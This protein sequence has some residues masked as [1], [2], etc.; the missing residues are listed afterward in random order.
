MTVAGRSLD[1]TIHR[2]LAR[3][4]ATIGID[5]RYDGLV[6]RVERLA[7]IGRRLDIW[8][9]AL[10]AAPD[11]PVCRHRLAAALRASGAYDRAF[12]VIEEAGRLFPQ[13]L[14]TMVE[15]ARVAEARSEHAGASE[16]WTRAIAAA[17]TP[18]PRWLSRAA[19]ALVVLGRFDEAEAMLRKAR[20]DHPRRADLLATACVLATSR[21]DWTQAVR[22]STEFQR[23]FP[24][25][26]DAWLL[27][28]AARE[29]AQLSEAVHRGK[30]P[31]AVEA[32]ADVGRVE[33][34]EARRLLLGFAGLGENCEFGLVQR[35]FGA[36]PVDLLRWNIVWPESLIEALEHGLEG[37]GEPENTE[38]TVLSNGEF[39]V[40]DT[41][42]YLGKH[43]FA[44]AGQTTHEA[45]Y[46][47]VCQRIAIQRAR[48]VADLA[49]A[50]RIFVYSSAGLD[51]ATL[52]ALHKALQRF[53][54]ARLLAVQPAEPET[55]TGFAG[56][57]GDILKLAPGCFVGFLRR[58]GVAADGSWNI[59][60]AD[61]ISICRKAEAASRVAAL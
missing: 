41:R 27:A 19:H 51:E 54:P 12:E 28:G 61:W 35:R 39:F 31:T 18:R 26:P 25:H 22:L 57:P 34:E 58:S 59:A 3:L 21:E 17:R 10:A 44:F 16:H 14:G 36:E 49:A 55:P 56:A 45:L 53:G 38:L 50:E 30:V 6:D 4:V 33:D 23:R 2:A 20:A 5:G 60:F 46:P 11:L 15:A 40:S 47:K 32:P 7:P 1:V 13:D 48:F 43:T 29:G 42:W 37:V 8:Q 9:A 24:K 52:A